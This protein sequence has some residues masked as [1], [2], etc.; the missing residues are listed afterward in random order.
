V[1]KWRT[2]CFVSG[3]AAFKRERKNREEQ[4]GNELK[5]VLLELDDYLNLGRFLKEMQTIFYKH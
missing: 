2:G 5:M 3:H 4:K 1:K